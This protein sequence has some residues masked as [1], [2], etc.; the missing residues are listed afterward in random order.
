MNWKIFIYSL[1]AVIILFSILWTLFFKKIIFDKIM[2]FTMEAIDFLEKNKLAISKK[3][4]KKLFL[5]NGGWYCLLMI[6]LFLSNYLFG[7]TMIRI[8]LGINYIFRYLSFLINILFPMSILLILSKS[9]RLNVHKN[10]V[11]LIDI[12][13][14]LETPYFKEQNN[15]SSNN[16]FI[17]T[18]N[19]KIIIE[20][21]G[22]KNSPYKKFDLTKIKNFCFKKNKFQAYKLNYFMFK[23][24]DNV[25]VNNKKISTYDELS[26][27]RI[28]LFKIINNS[29]PYFD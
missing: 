22:Q 25:Y 10:M 11:Q 4:F 16:D 19:E 23:N 15:D 5:I 13:D 21:K 24:I 18:L 29:N 26:L 7:I 20:F 3:F 8:D 12:V 1:W 27:L 2:F 14:R 9:L 28:F 6:P 17:K